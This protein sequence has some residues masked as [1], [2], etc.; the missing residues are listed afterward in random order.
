[1]AGDGVAPVNELCVVPAFVAHTEV[2][3]HNGGIVDTA[4]HASFVGGDDHH[5]LFVDREASVGHHKGAYHLIIRPYI[6]KTGEGNG[7]LHTGVVG[8]EGDDVRHAH[9]GKLLE[10]NSAVH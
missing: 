1:M 2:K 4:R 7:V 5:M 8:V 9:P 6:L 10:R 3:P